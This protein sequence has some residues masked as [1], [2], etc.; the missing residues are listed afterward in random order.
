MADAEKAKVISESGSKLG[1]EPK[2][3]KMMELNALR[4]E[5]SEKFFKDNE[6]SVTFFGVSMDPNDCPAIQIGVPPEVDQNSLT[7]PEELAAVNIMF[8]TMGWPTH[9]GRLGAL[10]VT[11]ECD[12]IDEWKDVKVQILR[13]GGCLILLVATK[14]EHCHW[15]QGSPCTDI[16]YWSKKMA[17]CKKRRKLWINTKQRQFRSQAHYAQD[18]RF[19][20]LCDEHGLL[21]WEE[22]LGWQNTPQELVRWGEDMFDWKLGR[23]CNE[24][25][26]RWVFIDIMIVYACLSTYAQSG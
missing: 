6:G 10:K 22:V 21:V 4:E 11:T 13:L 1:L 17:S 3:Q 20:D 26:G 23:L 5:L 14:L 19:L 7:I 16:P 8:T 15:N 2:V 12:L 9:G 25:G 24:F 18:Q